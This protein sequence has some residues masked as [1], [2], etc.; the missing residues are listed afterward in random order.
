MRLAKP[1]VIFLSTSHVV[2]L[3][4][5]GLTGRC[6]LSSPPEACLSPGGRPLQPRASASFGGEEPFEGAAS[7][8]LWFLIHGHQESSKAWLPGLRIRSGPSSSL[9]CLTGQIS[10]NQSLTSLDLSFLFME[11]RVKVLTRFG[12]NRSPCSSVVV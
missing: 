6:R 9:S 3:T 5:Q 8:V 1:A 12:E 4:P 10:L 11:M 2:A 7:P